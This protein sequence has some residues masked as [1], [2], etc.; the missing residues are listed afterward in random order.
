MMVSHFWVL[1][2][3]SILTDAH[4]RLASCKLSMEWKTISKTH[5]PECGVLTVSESRNIML[6]LCD[7]LTSRFMFD[8]D[9]TGATLD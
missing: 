4:E 8:P 3:G 6:L 2:R 7:E 5:H 1:I 9:L